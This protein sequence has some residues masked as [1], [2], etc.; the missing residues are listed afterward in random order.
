MNLYMLEWSESQQCYNIGLLEEIC[1][2]NVKARLEHRRSDYIPL[3]FSTD[4]ELLSN[5]AKDLDEQSPRRIGAA[6]DAI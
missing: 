6:H 5:F 2:K 4:I 3:M 1:S